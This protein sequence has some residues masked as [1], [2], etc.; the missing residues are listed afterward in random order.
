MEKT[1]AKNTKIQKTIRM[2]R[3]GATWCEV[4][5]ELRVTRTYLQKLLRTEY[6]K[7]E[8]CYNNLL[9]KARENQKN[10]NANFVIVTETGAL[11]EGFDIPK[12]VK[13]IVPE[14]CKKEV[15]KYAARNGR[16]A[17]KMVNDP[18]II[19]VPNKH[20]GKLNIEPDKGLF[21]YRSINIVSLACKL[22]AEGNTVRCV[23]TSREIWELAGMQK[24]NPPT[25]QIVK[26]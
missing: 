1:M 20:D 16:N 24:V 9:K 11:F 17:K 7:N 4:E 10:K 12:G 19:W 15:T 8:T 3:N 18:R 21:K 22:L 14:F 5:K 26:L 13:V 25:L 6:Y 2:I 23:T